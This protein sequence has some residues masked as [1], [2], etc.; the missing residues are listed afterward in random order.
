MGIYVKHI[1]LL[2]CLTK[3]HRASALKLALISV[4][5]LLQQDVRKELLKFHFLVSQIQSPVN[6]SS[7]WP[8]L[9]FYMGRAVS[10]GGVKNPHP[11][12][13]SL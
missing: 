7:A 3:L 8:T 1:R 10:P 13:V 2:K 6:N 11:R 5:C 4:R 12:D 9:G